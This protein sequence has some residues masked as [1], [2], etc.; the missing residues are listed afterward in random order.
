ILEVRHAVAEKRRVRTRPDRA[1]RGPLGGAVDA[2]AAR[3]LLLARAARLR[4]LLEPLE[5]G[6]RRR[7]ALDVRALRARRRRDREGQRRE[8]PAPGI[9]PGPCDGNT[10]KRRAMS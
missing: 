7:R 3:A 10:R 1:E 6:R 4:V 9:L 8:G 5:R 2:L